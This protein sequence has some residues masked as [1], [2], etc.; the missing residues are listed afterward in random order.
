MMLIHIEILIVEQIYTRLL[1][2]FS[3][4]S[5]I[6]INE[7]LKQLTDAHGDF[8]LTHGNYTAYLVVLTSKHETCVCVCENK[9]I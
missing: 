3:P 8:G 4:L 1:M 7:H 2:C 6:S 9:M 5:Q